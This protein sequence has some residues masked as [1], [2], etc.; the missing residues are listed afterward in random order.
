MHSLGTGCWESARVHLVSC[1]LSERI[2]EEISENDGEE[3]MCKDCC[4][5]KPCVTRWN[6][7]M[8]EQMGKKQDHCVFCECYKEKP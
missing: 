1:R 3:I 6:N 8:E 4:G 2:Y 5:K 7:K